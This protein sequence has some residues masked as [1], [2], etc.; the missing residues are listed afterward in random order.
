[1]KVLSK[2]AIGVDIS[3]DDFVAR[4][5]YVEQG[6]E[7]QYKRRTKK[8]F[9]NTVKG[10]EAFEVWLKKH[11]QEGVFLSI[12]ME[13]TGVYH[14]Q[15]AYYLHARLYA[16]S[17]VLPNKVKAY[18]RSLNQKSKTDDID[19]DLIALMAAERQL[20][21]WIPL[22]PIMLNL[23]ALTRQR[24]VFIEQ[25]TSSK[26]QL[27]AVRHS[28]KQM[29]SVIKRFEDIIEV[30]DLLVEDVD[31]EL[32][33]ISSEDASCKVELERLCTIVGIGWI[34]AV[35]ILAET[36]G[37]KLFTRRSQLVK[38]AGLDVVYKQSGSSINGKTRISKQ[39]NSHIRAA[40]YMPA[41]SAVQYPGIFQ[42]IYQRIKERTGNGKMA[43][44][45]VERKLLTTMLALYR[46]K[47]DYQTDYHKR[48]A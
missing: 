45:A 33:Q 3:K 5:Y 17:I 30:L 32:K 46:N 10:C 38:Y 42:D 40:L 29:E 18:A 43:L 21:R 20:D 19:A 37:F 44:V 48:R 47:T 13:A 2:Q 34:T 23:K 39:G 6:V 22:S 7:P 8:K 36:D 14:E 41:M 24:Q 1:M 26:N 4:L 15:L 12:A 27:H 35:I 25:R 28:A 9:A 11:T 16:V 31:K